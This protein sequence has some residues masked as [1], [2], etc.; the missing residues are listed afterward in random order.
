MELQ[1]YGVMGMRWGFRKARPSKSNRSREKK[2]LLGTKRK[3]SS[4]EE[5]AEETPKKSQHKP[6][7]KVL[8]SDIK[9]MSDNEL[10]AEIDRLNL[11]KQYKE[12]ISQNRKPNPFV[13]RGQKAMMNVLFGTAE[14]M[15]KAYLKKTI[16]TKLDLDISD[17]KKKK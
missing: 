8:V 12:L 15:G 14:D 17:S 10:R 5:T 1:H 16:K 11:E 2:T 9:S 7:H 4:P 6:K 3:N 13:E